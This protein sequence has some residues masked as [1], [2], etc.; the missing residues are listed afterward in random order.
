MDIEEKINS[1][2][3]DNKL[4]CLFTHY[5]PDHPDRKRFAREY[6][7]ESSRLKKLFYYDLCEDAGANPTN[8]TSLLVFDKAWR[9]GHSSD[10]YEVYWHWRD[11][12]QFIDL[13]L[14]NS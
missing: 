13:F 6:R 14:E 8:K 4:P 3:Y 1:G 9:D 12:W 2:L 7:E 5:R 10:F 11:L